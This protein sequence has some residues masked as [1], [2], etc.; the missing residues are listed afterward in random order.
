MM[1]S[2]SGKRQFLNRLPFLLP[3]DPSI[4]P[5]TASNGG[6]HCQLYLCIKSASSLTKNQGLREVFLNF[7]PEGMFQF[8][9]PHRGR[10]VAFL[11]RQT[12]QSAG[13]TI[14][15][16]SVALVASTRRLPGPQSISADSMLTNTR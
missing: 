3:R 6:H 13:R 12:L 5:A 9:D 1:M 16:R 11:A 4:D 8:G 15:S 10:Q 7:V 14:M 2:S